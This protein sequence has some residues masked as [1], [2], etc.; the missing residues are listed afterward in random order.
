M[1]LVK[2]GGGAR[3]AEGG[4]SEDVGVAAGGGGNGGSAERGEGE[5]VGVTAG[6]GALPAVD[7]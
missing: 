7:S 1:E 4:E 6:G 2:G 5:D 3:S